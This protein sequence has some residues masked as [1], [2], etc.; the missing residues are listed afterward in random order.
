MNKCLR[1]K[2]RKIWNLKNPDYYK[3]YKVKN[4]GRIKQLDRERYH[5]I[6]LNPD[7]R[8]KQT[9]KHSRW[10]KTHKEQVNNNARKY[11]AK[12][13]RIDDKLRTERVIRSTYNKALQRYI[14]T[15]KTYKTNKYGLDYPGII[16]HLQPFPDNLKNYEIHHITPLSKFDLRNKEQIKIAFAPENH[17]WVTKEQHK[18]IHRDLNK[19]KDNQVLYSSN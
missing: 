1:K 5:R 10:E 2:Y 14:L 13:R 19:D 7:Y 16:T 4:K 3:K 8:A 6:K 17:M 11:W 12:R 18:Q 15:G 9:V